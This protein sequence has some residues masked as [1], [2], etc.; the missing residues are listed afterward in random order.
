MSSSE[1][2]QDVDEYAAWDIVM[3]LMADN[4][5]GADFKIKNKPGGE[6]HRV[7]VTGHDRLGT[8]T[9]VRGRL[10]HVIHG[11]LGGGSDDPATLIVF[12]WLLVPGKLG[13][14]FREVNIDVSFAPHGRRPGMGPGDD[15]ADYTPEVKTVV[16]HVPIKSLFS[17]AD[18]R[19]EESKTLRL[20]VGYDPLVALTP[21]ISKR[22]SESTQRTSYR[23][24]AGLATFKNKKWGE[25]NAVHWKLHENQSQESGAPH[26][27]RTAVLLRR[28]PG[29]DG[30]FTAKVRT[31][32]H[33]S[34]MQDAVESLRNTFGSRD[35]PIYF[36][37]V[38]IEVNHGAAVLYGVRGK[39]VIKMES[40]CDSHN[41]DME[42]LT[43]FLIKDDE[44]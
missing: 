12:E 19:T 36:D 16:P 24:A 10:Y 2:D 17:V 29:D 14:R 23:F 43:I 34:W 11:I 26:I 6:T 18:V 7:I 41:L 5:D 27:V 39:D 33:V 31:N 3:P 15:L 37:P 32:V 35:D 21:E 25:P 8:T 9:A 22:S 20:T 40:P 44:K 38:P 13:H 30:Q 4:S 1:E 28:Q 42:D